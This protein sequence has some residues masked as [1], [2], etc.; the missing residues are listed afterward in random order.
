MQSSQNINPQLEEIKI[1]IEAATNKAVSLVENLDI[2]Q[3][4]KRPQ[5]N[6]WSV[7]ECLVHINLTSEAEI[8]LLTET[9]AQHQSKRTRVE[10]E[11]KMELFSRLIKWTLEPP[12][13]FFS[14]LK[15][16]EQFQP[17]NVE[18][19]SE[20]MPKF[21]NLQEQ[22][23]N[24]VDNAN[25]LPL[26][27]IIVVSPFNAKVKYNLFSCF[28]LILAHERRHLWQAEQVKNAL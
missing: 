26:G 3:L 17:V 19:L 21:L 25:G 11:F 1:Q 15:T 20:V 22:L 10:K 7:A 12:P 6:K 16:T 28:H 24:C 5:P 4:I 9:Y 13:M 18:P 23:K 27:E 14:K 2:K 8:D